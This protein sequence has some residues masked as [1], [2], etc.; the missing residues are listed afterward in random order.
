M[1]TEEAHK[2]LIFLLDESV[3]RGLFATAAAVGAANN[4][5][6]V[7]AHKAEALD[8]LVINKPDIEEELRMPT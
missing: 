2:T 1:T 3:K 7:L 8:T 5:L 6:A 4:A